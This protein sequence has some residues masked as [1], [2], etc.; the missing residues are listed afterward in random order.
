MWRFSAESRYAGP[1]NKT[2]EPLWPARR[3]DG[4]K[5]VRPAYQFR[6]RL[7]ANSWRLDRAMRRLNRP[8][9]IQIIPTNEDGMRITKRLRLKHLQ[10]NVSNSCTTR[11]CLPFRGC[12]PAFAQ[13]NARVDNQAGWAI[14][15]HKNQFRPGLFVQSPMTLSASM[16][17]TQYLFHDRT[18]VCSLLV[19][20]FHDL[21]RFLRHYSR[22]APGHFPLP[23]CVFV[24]CVVHDL[25]NWIH[26]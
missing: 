21:F 1:K 17:R 9:P 20:L 19:N 15:W 6:L 7:S 23:P 10:S 8:W 3:A 5:Y 11:G 18:E 25:T 26:D 4:F 13:I 2:G 14:N 16:C 12:N 24:F 22:L